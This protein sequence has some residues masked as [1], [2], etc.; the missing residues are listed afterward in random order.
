MTV[1]VTHLN[2]LSAIHENQHPRCRDQNSLPI[3][4]SNE[5]RPAPQQACPAGRVCFRNLDRSTDFVSEAHARD[6][7][8]TS[9]I[10][11]SA[12][13]VHISPRTYP[14][15]PGALVLVSRLNR[16]SASP[17]LGK[18]LSERTRK[19]C[20]AG[21]KVMQRF[22]KVIAFHPPT[23]LARKHC[24]REDSQTESDAK[25]RHQ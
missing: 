13:M 9:R 14:M 19:S 3:F 25:A 12:K 18:V 6:R 23:V 2:T 20:E 11:E 16:F 8:W 1:S 5:Q 17:L 22:A 21:G 7:R 24:D 10:G 15:A 4:L